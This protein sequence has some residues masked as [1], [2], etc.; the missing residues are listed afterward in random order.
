VA[1]V[2]FLLTRG[3]PQQR[4]FRSPRDVL[5]ERW[6]QVLEIDEVLGEVLSTDTVGH[7]C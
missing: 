5:Q 3:V 7:C 6:W 2:V 4:L 1:I